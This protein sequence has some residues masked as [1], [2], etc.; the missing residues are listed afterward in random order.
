MNKMVRKLHEDISRAPR[1]FA[2]LCFGAGMY[3]AMTLRSD[4]LLSDDALWCVTGLVVIAG[5]VYFA[6]NRKEEKPAR[7][8]ER[9]EKGGP[10]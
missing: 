1:S 2:F 9:E 6:T 10:A 4:F 3:T 7:T 8:G 5:I